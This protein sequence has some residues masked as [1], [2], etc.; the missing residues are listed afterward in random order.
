MKRVLLYL[1]LGLVM[2]IPLGAA[3]CSVVTGSGETATWEMDYEDFNKIEIGSAFEAQINRADSFLVSITIDKKLYEYLKIEQRGDT[4]HIGLKPNYIYRDTVQQ[5]TVN[6]PDLRR[7]ELSGAS[8]ATVGG[9]IMTHSLDFELSGASQLELGHTIAGNGGFS[10][11][12]ASRANGSI[13]MDDGKFDLSGASRISISGTAKNISIDASG[14]SNVSL[15][16]LAALTADV[17]LSGA[18]HAAISVVTSMSID[19][20]GASGLEYT[21]NPKLGK[22]DMSGGSTLSKI[23]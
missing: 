19:L 10:L 1:A 20:S 7:L 17:N 18:S 22:I 4:L 8:K 9:F 21:G 12:G 2:L 5:A 15:K 14:A 23:S 11:S 16:E 6:L 13:E 3:G